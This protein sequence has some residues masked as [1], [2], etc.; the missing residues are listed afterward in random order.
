MSQSDPVYTWCNHYSNSCFPTIN[1]S[2]ESDTVDI[3]SDTV[4]GVTYSPEYPPF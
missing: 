4:I 1:N 3:Y 2:D